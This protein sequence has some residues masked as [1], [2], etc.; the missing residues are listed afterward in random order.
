MTL[1][2]GNLRTEDRPDKPYATA[3]FTAATATT[4][5]LV[6]TGLEAAWLDGKTLTLKDGQCTTS[7]P[8]GDHRLTVSPS[9]GAPVM[10]AQCDEVTFT[11]IP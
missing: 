8:A 3:T 6:L 1:V 4:K 7:I 10:K 5:P 11:A 9:K 2:N